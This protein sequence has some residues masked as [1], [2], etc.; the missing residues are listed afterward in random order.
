VDKEVNEQG[1][2]SSLGSTCL[3]QT[4]NPLGQT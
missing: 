3:E 4:R 1:E 2:H